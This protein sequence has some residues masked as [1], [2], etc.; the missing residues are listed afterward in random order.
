MKGQGCPDPK[1]SVSV[2]LLSNL[3]PPPQYHLILFTPS[4]LPS[5]QWPSRK[6]NSSTYILSQLIHG[7]YII[8][9]SRQ[10]KVVRL[11]PRSCRRRSP[12]LTNPPASREVVHHPCSQ[13]EGEDC[14]GCLAAGSR[15]SNADVQF[16]RIQRC[17]SSF[18][19]PSGTPRDDPSHMKL[20]RALSIFSRPKNRLPSLRLSLLHRR[21]CL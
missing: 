11:T 21:L 18:C 3:A 1:R 8:L 20:T 6:S 15:A 4:T 5:T 9:L 2:R 7:R 16:S 13:R 19:I 12:S 17:V 10:G 14:Q